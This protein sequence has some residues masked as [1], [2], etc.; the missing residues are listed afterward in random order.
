MAEE[1][2]AEEETLT[3]KINKNDFWKYSTFILVAVLI[4]GAF[5]F[6]MKGDGNTP[7]I[8]TGNVVNN[9]GDAL[10]PQNE[11]VEV[12]EDDD[13]VLGNKDAPVTIIEF[14][15]Y[16]CPFCGRHFQETYPQLKK[17]YIDTGKVKLVYRDFP[18]SF[19]PMAMP[20]ALAAE[21]VKE[22]GGDEGY[23]KFHDKVFQN[24]QSL[25]AENLKKWARELGY[26]INT[27]FDSQKYRGEVQNDI[28]EGS[29]AGVQGTPS[30]FI[31]GKQLSGAQPFAAF[32]QAIDAELA[33]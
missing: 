10:P 13:A 1:N 4:V 12:D 17:D 9:P 5:V 14:S 20:A 32:Q 25:N 30:F 33:A 26:D 28:Q 6:F 27:C 15:D 31:N 24:Q 8:P 19:H 21:C 18:L 11:R 3:I 22:K 16:E 23:F 2:K 7:N 29:A